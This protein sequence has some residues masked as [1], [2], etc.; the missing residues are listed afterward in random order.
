MCE[1]GRDG[2]VAPT[3]DVFLL[4]HESRLLLPKTSD[5]SEA[6]PFLADLSVRTGILV[7]PGGWEPER[8]RV[9]RPDV[10]VGYGTWWTRLDVSPDHTCNGPIVGD[11]RRSDLYDGYDTP[12]LMGP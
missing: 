4:F 6:T 11:S 3:S 8:E 10:S 9:P 5:I 7:P 1:Q 2:T 12:P